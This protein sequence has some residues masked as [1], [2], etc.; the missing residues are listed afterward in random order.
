MRSP[1][2][3]DDD[4]MDEIDNEEDAVLQ[5][6]EQYKRDFLAILDSIARLP[7]PDPLDQ[8]PDSKAPDPSD[9]ETMSG[10]CSLIRE[11][12]V[13]P[14]DFGGHNSEQ[15][16]QLLVES[17]QYQCRGKSHE[18]IQK[19]AE[20]RLAWNEVILQEEESAEKR[21]HEAKE[22]E[23][24]DEIMEEGGK[25]ESPTE[26]ED[27][28]E[29]LPPEMDYFFDEDTLDDLSGAAQTAEASFIFY[30]WNAVSS[31]FMSMGKDRTAL[32][33]AWRA[34]DIWSEYL[35]R[36]PS[37]DTETIG[38]TVVGNKSVKKHPTEQEHSRWPTITP[39]IIPILQKSSG[40][41]DE[42]NQKAQNEIDVIA[43]AVQIRKR[44]INKPFMTAYSPHPL[45]ATMYM[46]SIPP[47]L[48][49]SCLEVL[50]YSKDYQIP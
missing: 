12:I 15:V 25:M 3:D 39:D 21:D 45:S 44:D 48:L 38:D 14:S 32:Q 7:S 24:E 4:G 37:S 18:A 9:Y 5:E 10:S 27:F 35:E 11:V 8:T 2:R 19:L 29:Q 6:Q 33:A 50:Q 31:L 26:E 30:F 13:P 16:N 23:D 46:F 28:Q 41:S 36:T 34:R 42:E 1:G 40:L 17:L 22:A 47:Q 49:Q 20:A 43:C